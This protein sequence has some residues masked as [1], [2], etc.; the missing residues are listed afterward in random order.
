M[1]C[2]WLVVVTQ[3]MGSAFIFISSML[4]TWSNTCVNES[5][6]LRWERRGGQGYQT[7]SL[8]SLNWKT[9]YRLK[10]HYWDHFRICITAFWHKEVKAQVRIWIHV[11]CFHLLVLGFCGLFYYTGQ[12]GRNYWVQDMKQIKFDP[13]SLGEDYSVPT[14]FMWQSVLIQARSTTHP[15]YSRTADLIS[16]KKD[17][18]AETWSQKM[19]ASLGFG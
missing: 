17:E 10:A 11:D 15:S 8:D 3:S 12:L 7:E 2:L 5:W 16:H 4:L 14:A 18:Q 9:V 19:N 6:V 1:V 13:A